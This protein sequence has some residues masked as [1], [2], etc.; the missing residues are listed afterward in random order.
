MDASCWERAR[1]CEE[2]AATSI[3]PEARK[4]WQCVADAW[5]FAVSAA[6]RAGPLIRQFERW[7]ENWRRS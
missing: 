5:Y 7:K 3:H 1:R 2:L 4:R 6:E